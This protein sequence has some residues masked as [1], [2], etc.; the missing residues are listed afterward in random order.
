MEMNKIRLLRAIL[1]AVGFYHMI[2]AIVHFFG[3]TLF[4]F[5]HASLYSPYHDTLIA[6]AA[7]FISLIFFVVAKNPIKYIQ[8]LHALLLMGAIGIVTNIWILR[9]FNFTSLGASEKYLQTWIELSA[10]SLVTLVVALLIPKKK[11]L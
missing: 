7:V 8:M 3:I 4:P 5:Y 11:S 6:M 10:L 1:Y 2:A 9:S